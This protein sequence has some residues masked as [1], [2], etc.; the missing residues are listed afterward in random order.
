MP[1]RHRSAWRRQQDSLARRRMA[2]I[3]GI[4]MAL[5]LVVGA[6]VA[7]SHGFTAQARNTALA[8]CASPTASATGVR[9]RAA[10]GASMT[11]SGRRPRPSWSHTSGIRSVPGGSIW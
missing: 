10:K 4:P 8:N 9:A 11:K 7:F 3:I 5:A 6:I 1:R 2:V